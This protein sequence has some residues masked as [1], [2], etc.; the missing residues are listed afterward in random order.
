MSEAKKVVKAYS[1]VGMG[2][3]DKCKHEKVR[4]LDNTGWHAICGFGVGW[5]YH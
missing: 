1:V 5:W 2:T 4:Y 3:C